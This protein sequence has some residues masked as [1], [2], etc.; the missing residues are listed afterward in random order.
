[1]DKKT[2]DLIFKY[3]LQNAI[4]Y[5]GK[6]NPGAVLGK[7]LSE[8]PDLRKDVD[9]I[10]KAI[11]DGV[12]KVNHMNPE[13][14]NRLFQESGFE[15]RKSEKVKGLPELRNAEIGKVVTRFAPSP[16][17]PLNISHTLRGVL[18]SY[19]YAR[20]YKGRFILRFEDTDAKKV[21]K[22]YYD[23]IQE[24]LRNLGVEWDKLIIQS[25]RMAL[26]Y[27][28]AG[29]MI[30]KGSAFVCT[31][32]QDDFK[33]YVMNKEVCKCWMLNRKENAER[34]KK[35]LE[36][37][38][39]E[40]E[41]VLR[42]KTDMKSPNPV[43]RCPAL[44]RISKVEHPL[45]GKKYNAWPLYN[46]ANVIDDHEEGVTHVFRGKEHEHNTAVQDIVYSDFKWK[47]PTVINFGMIYLP[48]EKLHTRDIKEGIKEGKYSGWDDIKLFTLR[49]LFRRGFQPEAFFS[50]AEQTG[51]SKTDIVIGIENL[52]G[53]N[54]KII[55]K[56]ANRY[57]VV[58]DPIK[59]SVSGL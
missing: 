47:P 20:K 57:M 46:F 40:G 5:S 14:Q 17:G 28:Y 49:S 37:G 8:N 30:D 53:H 3:C 13:E 18:I 16:T 12:M 19:I 31:C 54:K 59:L 52:E 56:M 42:L 48:G 23:W 6:A 32:S 36:G 11:N 55:D 58:I 4:S 24:D 1:M 39:K 26:Y 45:A 27:K 35:L 43:L 9:V 25:E 33:K 41:A 15:I 10:R 34:W 50:F 38:Y 29:E 7:V 44:F 22:R 21:E 51:L 2:T